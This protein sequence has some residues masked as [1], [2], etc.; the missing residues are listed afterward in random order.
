MLANSVSLG[1]LFLGTMLS[2]Q[3]GPLSTSPKAPPSMQGVT[4][5]QSACPVRLCS[6]LRHLGW[7]CANSFPLLR[8]RFDAADRDLEIR[9]KLPGRRLS[10]LHWWRVPFPLVTLDWTVGLRLAMRR[11]VSRLV[12]A[13]LC[14]R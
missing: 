14:D 10:H 7:S 6:A 12:R 4:R 13:R 2:R 3:P 1:P 11:L 5:D 9:F 8:P